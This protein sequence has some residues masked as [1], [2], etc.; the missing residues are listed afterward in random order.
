MFCLDN[1][2]GNDT[3]KNAFPDLYQME[4]CKICR[5]NERIKTDGL[6]W[7][8]KATLSSME[9]IR[10]LNVLTSRLGNFQ[11]ISG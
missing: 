4:K 6:N 5:V 8:W 3:L 2:C 11:P 7:K 10:D 1:W 9:H